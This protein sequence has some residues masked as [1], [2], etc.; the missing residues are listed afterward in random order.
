MKRIHKHLI[1][2]SLCICLAAPFGSQGVADETAAAPDTTN[3][4]CRMCTVPS[5]WFGEWDLGV[6]FVSDPSLKFGDYRGLEDDDAYLDASG[7]LIYRG[8]NGRYFDF[9]GQ[10]LGLDSRAL[11]MRGGKRGKYQLRADYSEIPRYLGYGTATPYSGVGTDTLTLPADWEFSNG[12][13]VGIEDALRPTALDTKRETAGAGVTV[14]FGKSWKIE[15]DFER[16]EKNGTRAFSGGTFAISAGAFP[17]PVDYSTD[18]FNMGLE[19]TGNR[20]QFR[21]GFSG[22]DFDNGMNSVTW[23]SPTALGFGDELARSALEPDNEFQQL[24]LSGAVRFT[25]NFR[26]SAKA[27]VGEMEQN[28]LFLPYSINPAFDELVLPR[29]SLNGKV[30][31]SMF[32]FSG[33]VFARLADGIDLTLQH[34][35][36]ERE[37][38]TPVDDYTQIY[39]EVFEVGEQANKPFG[40]DRTQSRMELRWRPKHNY[41]FSAGFKR[42]DGSSFK[43]RL[44]LGDDGVEVEAA[45]D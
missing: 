20:S 31:T 24:S 1:P 26:I 6:I 40:Y 44:V 25:P 7:N 19:F 2:A 30:D 5:G 9:Y 34:K 23:D 10:D 22:S 28:D 18:L 41:R 37:N 33:R 45:G 17:A 12:Q 21:L 39:L 4:V 8:E 13:F 11:E 16:Q 32:N 36:S 29:T 15:A 14:K 42:D 38:E 43:G 35:V 3:W 27:S